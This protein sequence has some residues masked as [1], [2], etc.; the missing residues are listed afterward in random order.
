MIGVGFQITATN[1][2]IAPSPIT[3]GTDIR[4]G[5]THARPQ[6]RSFKEKTEFF[7]TTILILHAS[8]SASAF[9]LIKD[10]DAFR[11]SGAFIPIGLTVTPASRCI[12]L[13]ASFGF[14]LTGT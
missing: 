1:R 12:D 10:G 5:S 6:A 3:P 11:S 2:I 4:L 7:L 8:D 13:N 14:G 9:P